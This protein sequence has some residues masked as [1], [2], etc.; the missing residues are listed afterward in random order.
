MRRH[1]EF[2]SDVRIIGKFLLN[3]LYN[4]QYDAWNG[5]VKVAMTN[6]WQEMPD[7]IREMLNVTQDMGDVV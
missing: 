5:D 4:G 1:L 2:L 7:V 6:V 3:F